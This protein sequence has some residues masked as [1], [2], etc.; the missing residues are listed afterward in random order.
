MIF[1][2]C[3][4]NQ[5]IQALAKVNERYANNIRFKQ[6]PD[7]VGRRLR[8]TLTV[9]SSRT[10]GGRRSHTGRRI[11]AAC[12]HVHG[13]FFEALFC[14]EP[15]TVI[16]SYGNRIDAYGG[17]WQDRNIGSIMY[18]MNYSEACDCRETEAKTRTTQT[19]LVNQGNLSGECMLVQIWGTSSCATCEYKGTEDCG[20]KA[21]LDTGKNKKGIPVGTTGL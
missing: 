8:A 15:K 5:M 1:K 19:K 14:I 4:K 6:G 7:A 21:I 10:P 3:T 16:E 20:G 9:V 12:W 2:N 17:N 13:W 18:P 11:A